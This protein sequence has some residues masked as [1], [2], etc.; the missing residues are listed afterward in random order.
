MGYLRQRLCELEAGEELAVL[1]ILGSPRYAGQ[2]EAGDQLQVDLDVKPEADTR[3]S[4][5]MHL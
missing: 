4:F 1:C 2:H 5:T 3:S